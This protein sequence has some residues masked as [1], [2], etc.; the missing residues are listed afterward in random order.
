M[1]KVFRI[2][3]IEFRFSGEDVRQA[4]FNLDYGID[5]RTRFYTKIEEKAYPIRQLFIEMAKE[6]GEPIPDATTHEAIRVLR[7]LGFK[8][9]EIGGE[10]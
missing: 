5:S 1:V 4:A 6:K 8:I 7:S 9:F 3:G 2:K 10:S